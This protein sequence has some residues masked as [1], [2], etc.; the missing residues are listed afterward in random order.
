MEKVYIH[1]S[2]ICENKAIYSENRLKNELRKIIEE[3]KGHL[4]AMVKISFIFLA[5]G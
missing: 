5:E 1:V 2:G 3:S 4:L